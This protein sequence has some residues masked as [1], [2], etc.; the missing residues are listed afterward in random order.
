M[1]LAGNRVAPPPR[2]LLD[3]SIAGPPV[4][5]VPIERDRVNS[6]VRTFDTTTHTMRPGQLRRSVG[7]RPVQIIATPGSGNGAALT[8]AAGLR[9]ALRAHAHDVRLDVFPRLERLRRW[10]ATDAARFSLLISVGG[11]ATQSAAA[12]AA[13]RRSVPLLPV[14]VGFGNLFARAFRLPN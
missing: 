10:T 8:G 2:M 14:P 5:A 7:S 13:M 6:R 12:M 9:E 11:D 3:T 1:R 4:G